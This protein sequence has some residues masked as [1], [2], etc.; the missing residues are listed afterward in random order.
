MTDL[1]ETL[2]SIMLNTEAPIVD[3]GTMNHQLAWIATLAARTKHPGFREEAE[4]RYVLRSIRGHHPSMTA[5]VYG[6]VYDDS[7]RAAGAT[8]F[9]SNGRN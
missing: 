9:E 8:M 3:E 1:R 6:R 5:S 2:M 4:W 7:F